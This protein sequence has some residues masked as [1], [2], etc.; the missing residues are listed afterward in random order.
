V[1]LHLTIK[2]L[3]PFGFPLLLSLE[4]G[5]YLPLVNHPGTTVLVEYSKVHSFDCRR[6][7]FGDG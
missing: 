4:T 1:N 5:T 6:Q 2:V 7:C 3:Q